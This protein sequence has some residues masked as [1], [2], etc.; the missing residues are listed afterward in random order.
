MEVA[1]KEGPGGA[2]DGLPDRPGTDGWGAGVL[3]G[4][5]AGWDGRDTAPLMIIRS[6][7]KADPRNL[8][9]LNSCIVLH[10]NSAG[11]GLQAG[12]FSGSNGQT[13]KCLNFPGFPTETGSL[14]PGFSPRIYSGHNVP[15]QAAHASND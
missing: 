12:I 8:S 15:F 7:P 6:V 13:P 2:A 9:N 14:P 5:E 1:S 4:R 3:A 10:F 11:C